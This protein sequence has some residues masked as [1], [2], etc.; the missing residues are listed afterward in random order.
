MSRFFA[1]DLSRLPPPDAVVL[2]VTEDLV[3]LR[4]QAVLDRIDD[5]ALRADV[6]LTLGL[7]SEP[8][9]IQNEVGAFRE[10]LVYQ[11]INE[12]VRANFFSTARGADLDNMFSWLITR[13][14]KVATGWVESDGEFKRRY[15]AALEAFSTCGSEGGY[16]FYALSAG[17]DGRVKDVAVYGP[18]NTRET[19][20]GDPATATSLG[21][22]NGHVHLVVLARDGDGTASAALL[23]QVGA[24]C[25]PK[26]RRPLGDWVHPMA[27]TITPY[28]VNYRLRIGAGA[29]AGLIRSQALARITAYTAA[30]HMV[31]AVV[32]PGALDAAAT[33]PDAAGLPLVPQ[34]IRV[35]PAGWV[36]AG[37]YGAPRCTNITVT[38]EVVDD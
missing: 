38:T 12:G 30:Q 18:H 19:T 28:A 14:H 11:R 10:T 24:E 33:V 3:T 32:S 20:V 21:V 2:P 13:L 15:Q 1:P 34:P 25:S 35:S 17:G 9:T 7:E 29:D 27:A 36:D 31:G 4:K 26:D 8:L 5:P 22:P 23:N 16:A 37:A 6:A